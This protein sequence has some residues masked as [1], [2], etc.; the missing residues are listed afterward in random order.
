MTDDIIPQGQRS[1]IGSVAFEIEKELKRVGGTISKDVEEHKKA[2]HEKEVKEGVEEANKTKKPVVLYVH[3]K[4]G[5]REWVNSKVLQN[6]H[7]S[8]IQPPPQTYDPSSKMSS[9]ENINNET[10]Q[11]SSQVKM[12]N[13]EVPS[14]QSTSNG[15]IKFIDEEHPNHDVPHIN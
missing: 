12:D 8:K 7:P 14:N 3:H 15:G 1:L 9:N 11:G 4:P 6:L 10:G 5:T 13:L 2:E